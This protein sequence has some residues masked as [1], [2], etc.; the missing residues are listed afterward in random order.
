MA[1]YPDGQSYAEWRGDVIADATPWSLS[2]ATPFHAEAN[3]TEWSSVYVNIGTPGVSGCTVTVTFYTDE[4]KAV[5]IVAP[6]WVLNQNTNL[7]CQIPAYG[8]YMAIDVTSV[9]AIAVSVNI[10][11]LPDNLAVPSIRY[12]N[13]GNSVH[14][15]SVSIPAS[16]TV[17]A[18][19]PHVTEGPVVAWVH[20]RTGSAKLSWGIFLVNVDGT[21]G[22][23]VYFDSGPFTS[24]N[25]ATLGGELPLAIQVQNT[26]AAGAHT[27]DYRMATDGR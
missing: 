17:T 1:G 20:D 25:I 16:G 13:L 14:A 6:T 2:N 21:L 27:C 19:L 22:D 7:Q 11:C 4:T 3:I 15:T 12:V 18:F 24:D 8:G 10:F 26:D 5:Q 9:A 23:R